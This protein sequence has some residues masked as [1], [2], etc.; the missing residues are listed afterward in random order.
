HGITKPKVD[1]HYGPQITECDDYESDPYEGYYGGRISD[2]RLYGGY[3]DD[4]FSEGG[5]AYARRR[6]A[7]YAGY[8]GR[9]NNRHYYS[10]PRCTYYA[11]DDDWY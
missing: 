10:R 4:E 8:G 9:R 7:G 3:S 6:L 5:C 2:A 11:D 1:E